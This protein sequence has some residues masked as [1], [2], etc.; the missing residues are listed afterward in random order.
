MKGIPTTLT[1]EKQSLPRTIVLTR[2]ATHGARLA[3]IV[4]V[5]FDGHTAL[6]GGFISDHGMQFGKRPLALS[7]VGLALLLSRFLAMLAL[8]TFADVYQ[9]FQSNKGMWVL[10]DNALTYD[11]IGVLLQPSLSL[12][13]LHQT[14]RRCTSAFLLKTLSK[15]RVMVGLGNHRFTGMEGGFSFHRTTDCQITHPHIDT[16]NTGLALWGGIGGLDF[17]GDEQVELFTGFVIP[18]FSRSDACSLLEKSHVLTISAVWH[19]HAPIQT[20]ETDL[21]PLLEAIIMPQLVGQRG[22]D[23]LGSLIK[24]F[25][26]FLGQTGLACSHILFDLRPQGFVGGTHLTWDT[27]SHLS[28]KLE[29]SAYLLIRSLLQTDLV[30]HL[31]MFKSVLTDI[32]QSISIGQLR[33][34]QGLELLGRR[35]RFE[36]SRKRC[37]HLSSVAKFHQNVKGI[38]LMRKWTQPITPATRKGLLTPWMNRRGFRKPVWCDRQKQ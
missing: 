23:I 29:P 11:M 34:T 32:V 2:I 26:A 20:Q 13:H 19:N 7:D 37:V 1:D 31:A 33:L 25:I 16:D 24:P 4:G 15:S 8:G 12:A 18:E 28:R 17:K 6:Q 38:K 27:T 9:V 30:A 21:L 3:R 35:M 10:F 14:A 5:H 22:R 36:F